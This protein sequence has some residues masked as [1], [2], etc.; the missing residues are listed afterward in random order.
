MVKEAIDSHIK[1][2]I[3]MIK[4][5]IGNMLMTFN[6]KAA[7]LDLV[8]TATHTESWEDL[9]RYLQMARWAT[10]LATSSAV[11]SAPLTTDKSTFGDRWK[12]RDTYVESELIYAYAKTSRYVDLKFVSTPN[13]ADVGKRGQYAFL[14]VILRS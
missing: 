9:V 8:D 11:T 14:W 1:V 12:T 6:P 5:M 13:Y 7:Y 10:A 4:M 2:I 3:R